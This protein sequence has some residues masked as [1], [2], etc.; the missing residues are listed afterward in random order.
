MVADGLLAKDDCVEDWDC[1]C[2]CVAVVWVDTKKG[3]MAP[4]GVAPL[5]RINCDGGVFFLEGGLWG[6]VVVVAAV[7]CCC[8]DSSGIDFRLR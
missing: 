4:T 2:C 3:S 1:D 8:C 5:V 6:V 7:S